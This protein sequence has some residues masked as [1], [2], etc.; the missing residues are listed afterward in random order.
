L[1]PVGAACLAHAIQVEVVAAEGGQMLAYQW[2]GVRQ[3]RVVGQVT[4]CAQLLDQF[5]S[6]D[7]VG[8]S[9]WE[10]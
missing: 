4:I 7:D 5:A 10:G 8:R 9:V 2:R 1:L 6:V 3:H